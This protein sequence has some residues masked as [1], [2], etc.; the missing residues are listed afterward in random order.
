MSFYINSIAC[1]NLRNICF[2]RY[3]FM[4]I[5]MQCDVLS[6]EIDNIFII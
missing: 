4:I 6:I 1:I 3:K 5:I 2:Y